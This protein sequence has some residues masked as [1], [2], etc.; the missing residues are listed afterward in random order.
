LACRVGQGKRVTRWRKKTMTHDDN[1]TP[2]PDWL[3]PSGDSPSSV[4]SG[5]DSGLQPLPEPAL[6]KPPL[7][8]DLRISWSW[9]HFVVLL[10]F[11]IASLLVVQT[12]FALIYAPHGRV[13]SQSELQRYLLSKPQFAIGTMLFWD[14]LVFLFLYMTLAVLRE[15]PFWRTLGWRKLLPTRRTPGNPWLYF[16]GGFALY[17]LVALSAAGITT[18]Q[19]APIEDLFKYRTTAFLFMAM[20]VLIAPLFEETVFRGYLYPLL[21]KSFGIVPSV[22]VT[23]IL[24]GLMHGY[25]LGWTWGLVAMLILVGIVLTLVRALTGTV[26]AS[27]LLHL[28]YNFS[29]AIF[30]VIATHGFTRMPPHP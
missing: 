12:I 1:P 19:N 14:A 20:A 8:E 18:P 4:P 21:A 24:F 17:F 7:P 15:Q 13:F 27:F 5:G 22:I 3:P 30:S 26:V 11:S 9:P 16:L 28:G 29:I 10:F 6:E 23:G 2:P 25:Q